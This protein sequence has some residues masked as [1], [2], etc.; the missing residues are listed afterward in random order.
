MQSYY[1]YLISFIVTFS[2]IYT[3]QVN[4]GDSDNLRKNNEI[5]KTE[6]TVLDKKEIYAPGNDG[7]KEHPEIVWYSYNESGLFDKELYS[8]YGE[9]TGYDT[10]RRTI[11]SY[12][13]DNRK[14]E[15]M[16][17][18]FKNYRWRNNMK[19]EF[20]YDDM[21]NKEIKTT[22]YY[23]SNYL[24]SLKERII[25]K[26]DNN[27]NLI[28]EIRQS[29]DKE[30]STWNND[31]KDVFKYDSI[32]KIRI[33]EYYRWENSGWIIM[34]KY[35]DE[36]IYDGKGRMIEWRWSRL[37][38]KDTIPEGRKKYEYFDS[39]NK[40][41]TKNQE[42]KKN[43]W[44]N[45]DR[46]IQVF[47]KKNNLVEEINQEWIDGEWTKGEKIKY[48][49]KKITDV[50]RYKT[51]ENIILIYPQPAEEIIHFK[52]FVKVVKQTRLSIHD[53]TGK[54]KLIRTINPYEIVKSVDISGL[55]EGFYFLKLNLEDQTYTKK[56]IIKR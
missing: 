6:K 26:Y 44:I 12:Y 40:K 8:Y 39:E 22:T 49:Y 7:W 29:L 27:N 18:I 2:L 46:K 20:E 54:E 14:K 19:F 17:E 50:E 36:Y 41:I 38:D 23:N 31:F 15:I 21:E 47:D 1:Y 11:H 9:E 55:P 16:D 51:E 45:Y 33:G 4:A 5:L 53:L 56:F 10:T 30:D 24:P 32:Q 48:Y 42:F 35:I 25:R 37:D 28:E 52:F 13:E 43:N 34:V 3:Y